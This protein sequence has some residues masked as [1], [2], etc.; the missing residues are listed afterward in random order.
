MGVVDVLIIAATTSTKI[1]AGWC[2]SMRGR[3]DNFGGDPSVKSLTPLDDFRLNRFP[4]NRQRNKNCLAFEAANPG[5][6]ECDIGY[7]QLDATSRKVLWHRNAE[8]Q[9]LLAPRKV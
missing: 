7:S 4:I 5:S 9:K 8:W 2:N 1:R 6:A 3:F